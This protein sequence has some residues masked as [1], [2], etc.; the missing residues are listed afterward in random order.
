MKK[1]LVIAGILGGA[2]YVA[3]KMKAAKDERAL[4]HEATTTTPDLR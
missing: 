1:L 4:W 2:A 3:R